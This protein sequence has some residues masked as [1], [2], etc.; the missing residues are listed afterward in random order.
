MNHS[1]IAAALHRFHDYHPKLIDLSLDRILQF[2]E[3]LGNPHHRLPP[4]IHVAGTNG[5]GSTV[6]TLRAI[7]EAHGKTVHTYI[8]PNLVRFNERI[9][10]AGKLIDDAQLLELIEHCEKIN[11]GAPITFF[12]MTTALAFEAF[13]RVPADFLLLE[14]GLGGRFDATN[15]ID[16]PLISVLTSISY[17]HKDFLGDDIL[18]IAGEKAG[19][20]KPRRPAIVG[21]QIYPEI[22]PVIRKQAAADLYIC[23]EDW[24]VWPEKDML[25]VSFKE[26]SWLVPPSALRGAHQN[27]NAGLAIAALNALQQRGE[28]GFNLES[29]KVATAMRQVYWPARMQ[30]L[31]TS[32]GHDLLHGYVG[33][34]YLDGGHNQDAGRIIA[35]QIQ[36]WREQNFA[37][38]MIIGMKKG[39]DFAGFLQAVLPFADMVQ[40]VPIEGDVQ[41]LEP[42]EMQDF[43]HKIVARNSLELAIETAKERAHEKRILLIA[44]SLYL[45]GEVL[46]K[47]NEIVY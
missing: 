7:L 21:R 5:K 1:G 34:V 47:N 36:I 18:G 10:L 2:L 42:Q 45:A 26:Q 17:D 27:E 29:D 23:G 24:N 28:L 41:Y 43:D 16:N 33:D 30:K 19:I 20:I 6:A 38:D 13:A 32:S 25:H 22:I 46:Q 37:V 14:V 15:V 44:G 4:V 35:A 9:R 31:S 8:S 11:D 39:K 40:A 12:E 3:K